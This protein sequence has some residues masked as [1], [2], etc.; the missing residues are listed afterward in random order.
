MKGSVLNKLME[1]LHIYLQ[2]NQVGLLPTHTQ[3]L[4]QS[5][6]KA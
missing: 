3:K 6:S 2:K 1:Q 4:P 5:G